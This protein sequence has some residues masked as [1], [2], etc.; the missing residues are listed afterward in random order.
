MQHASQRARTHARTLLAR[1]DGLP[2][3]V[4]LRHDCLVQAERRSAWSEAL[5]LPLPIAVV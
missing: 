2:A 5:F 4:K 3:R 1:M